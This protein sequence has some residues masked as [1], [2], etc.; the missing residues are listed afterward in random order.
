M[1]RR[2]MSIHNSYG[3]SYKNSFDKRSS[4]HTLKI[5]LPFFIFLVGLVLGIYCGQSAYFQ[6]VYR[7]FANLVLENAGDAAPHLSKFLKPSSQVADAEKIAVPVGAAPLG[8][9]PAT[10]TKSAM[11][12]DTT[13]HATHADTANTDANQSSDLT[14]TQNSQ[15][16]SVEPAPSTQSTQSTPSSIQASSVPAVSTSEPTSR[17]DGNNLDNKTNQDRVSTKE[18]KTVK[19]AKDLQDTNGVQPKQAVIEIPSGKVYPAGATPK[20][21]TSK[22]TQGTEELEENNLF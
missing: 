9:E 2:M 18:T 4:S 22:T 8:V 1:N 11:G 17:D 21:S 20:K 6:Q 5:I 3:S 13:T 10:V 19:E 7:E 14:S 16:S 15:N 12:T